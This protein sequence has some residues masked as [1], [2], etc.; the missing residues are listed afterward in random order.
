MLE[1]LCVTGIISFKDQGEGE[2]EPEKK[3][4]NLKDIIKRSKKYVR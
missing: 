1:V 2:K 4:K 3:K